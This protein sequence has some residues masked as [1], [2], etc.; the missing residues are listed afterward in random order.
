MSGLRSIIAAAL[1]WSF[2]SW[3]LSFHGHEPG[4]R[5]LFS[6]QY[7]TQSLLLTPIMLI[8]WLIFSHLL[9]KVFFKEAD[10]ASRARWFCTA[11]NTLASG[12]F[13]CWILPD[14]LV[15]T[16]WGFDALRYIVPILPIATTGFVL[17]RTTQSIAKRCKIGLL[18]LLG[19]T[20]A[21][22]TVQA[23]PILL[24]VR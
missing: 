22:W 2:F 24:F 10:L 8:S 15:Y 20:L 7:R 1:V 14:V 9:W 21:A 13:F 3:W 16:V 6:D 12:Y 23:I 4:G 5:S 17:W 18:R 19:W 11:G